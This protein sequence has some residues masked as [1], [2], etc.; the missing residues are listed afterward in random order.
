MVKKFLSSAGL[1]GAVVALFVSSAPQAAA[2]HGALIYYADGHILH[3]PKA[4]CYG[5]ISGHRVE[6]LTTS[7]VVLYPENSCAGDPMTD[8]KSVV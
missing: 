3:S 5:H 2:A 6:N 4:G 8:R 7:S 1:A